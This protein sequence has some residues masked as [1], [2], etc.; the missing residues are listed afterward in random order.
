MIQ[1]EEVN[2][3]GQL[4]D[5]EAL[6]KSRLGGGKRSAKRRRGVIANK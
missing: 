6:G 2:N 3:D 5:F 1:N 4:N